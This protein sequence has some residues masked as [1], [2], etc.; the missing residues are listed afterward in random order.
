MKQVRT[1]NKGFYTPCRQRIG[2][3]RQWIFLGWPHNPSTVEELS[4]IWWIVVLISVGLISWMALSPAPGHQVESHAHPVASYEEA[5]AYVKSMQE[6]DNKD[7]TRDVC[8]T[9]L[10]SHDMQ[11]DHVIVLLHGFTT[12]P[13]QFNE[14]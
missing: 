14:L 4:M 11:T 3:I 8:I 10:F 1:R 13:E 6:E 5:I 7:L 12:C 2:Q 9:M